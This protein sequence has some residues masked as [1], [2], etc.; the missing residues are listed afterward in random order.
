MN[1]IETILQLAGSGDMPGRIASILGI[2]R[3]QAGKAVDA[4]VPSL[5]AGLIGAASK[6]EGAAQLSGILSRQDTDLSGNPDNFPAG[7]ASAGT[8]G[9][10]PLGS[11]LGGGGLARI[12]GALSKFTGLDEGLISKLLGMLSPLVLGAIGKQARGLDPS[13]LASMLAGQKA[14]VV[15]ALPSGLGNLLSSA[16]PEL[17]NLLGSASSAVSSAAGAAGTAARTAASGANVA[18]SPLSKWLPPLVLAALAVFLLPRMCRR[19][20]D[21]ANGGRD[22][23]AGAVAAGNEGAAFITDA[24]HLISEATET[25]AGIRDE[26]TAATALPKLESITG[27]L[28]GLK[29]AWSRLPAAAQKAVAASLHPLIT[30][31]R[32]MIQPLL[33][34]P[35]VGEKIR[36]AVEPMLATLEGFAPPA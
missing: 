34:L 33:G 29:A 3:E 12:A 36:P 24:G 2:G 22:H 7:G 15:S 13:G 1:I 21:P 10:N 28:S 27:K 31:L 26:A 19:P 14:N 8:G 20:P 30:K 11:L 18:G 6:P 23:V 17:G 35:L 16:V 32:G 25:V 9:E 4:A 5:F